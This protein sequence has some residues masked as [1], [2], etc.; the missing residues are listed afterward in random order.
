MGLIEV[1]AETGHL[2]TLVGIAEQHE[3][4]DY[5][6]AETGDDERC[7][8]RMLVD[9]TQEQVVL[10]ALQTA[11][12]GSERFHI[13]LLP[14]EAVLPREAQEEEAAKEASQGLAATR[15]E[16]YQDVVQGTRL[17]AS[18]LV[19]VLLSTVVVTIGLITGSV[20]VVIGSMVIAPLLGPH[21]A[22]AFA[23]VLGDRHLGATALRTSAAGLALALA[24]SALLGLLVPLHHLDPGIL[25]RTQVGLDDVALALAS[26]AA[27][28]LSMTTGLPAVLV[29]VMVAVALLPPTA[30]TGLMLGSGRW[31]L[32]L[33]AGLLLAVNIVC[34]NLSAQVVLLIQGLRPRTWLERKK[35]Q[36]SV[37]FSLLFWLLALAVLVSLIVLTRYLLG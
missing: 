20:A 24:L 22:L 10:D 28:A 25:R 26:G 13:V 27:G 1:V 4:T 9:D 5:W 2:D 30:V 23:A 7:S 12:A 35:A 29:G 33:G 15:E 18:Y 17:N 19:L 6:R 36:Q 8:V 37:R 31:P 11:L 3:V 21:I 34:V 14:V 16:L 32:A